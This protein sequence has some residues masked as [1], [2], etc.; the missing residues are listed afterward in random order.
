[1]HV[2]KQRLDKLERH[3]RLVAKNGG[4]A[5]KFLAAFKSFSVATAVAKAKKMKADYKIDSVPT[6]A[7]HGRWITSPSLAGSQERAFAVVDQLVARART[8]K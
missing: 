4:D 1:M 8:G 7:V 2:E 6:L 3:R 5:A